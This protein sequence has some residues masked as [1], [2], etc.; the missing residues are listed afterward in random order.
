M[1][2]RLAFSLG[3]LLLAAAY[4]WVAF[5][6][7]NFMIRGRLGP[8][9]FPRIIGVATIVLTLYSVLV[10]VRRPRG[11]DAGTPYLRD[12]VV[13]FAYCF[14]FVFL[15]PYLGGMLSMIAF[16]LAALLTF[17]RG[18]PLLDVTIAVLLP[19]GLYLLFDVWL[20]AAFP[21]GRL[22]LPW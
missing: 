2:L 7:M 11:S 10:D 13:F 14:G 3:I 20:N 6:D 18:R 19:V 22:P 12:I 5:V 17:Y 16:M 15:L 9:F 8:G 4:T 1:T 21:P